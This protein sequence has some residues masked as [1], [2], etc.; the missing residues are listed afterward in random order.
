MTPITYLGGARHLM[1]FLPDDPKNTPWLEQLAHVKNF[2]SALDRWTLEPHDELV[3]GAVARSA[4]RASKVGPDDL[5]V[6]KVQAP[7]TT[8]WCLANPEKTYVVYVRGTSQPVTLTLGSNQARA[9]RAEQFD[10]R[11]GARRPLAAPAAGGLPYEFRPPD[12]QDWLVIVQA[13]K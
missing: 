1:T 9:W 4:D 13:A 8:Y 2:F 12:A 11:T 5:Q 10:P 7:A 6:A 3:T